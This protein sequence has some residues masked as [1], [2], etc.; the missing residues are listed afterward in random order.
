MCRRHAVH[1]LRALSNVVTPASSTTPI[2]CWLTTML[3]GDNADHPSDAL[4]EAF[5]WRCSVADAEEAW[6][7]SMASLAYT[8]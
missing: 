8:H 4:H 2:E 1:L 7:C 6:L 5:N 3:C